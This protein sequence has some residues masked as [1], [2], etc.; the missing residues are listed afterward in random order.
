MDP[1][2]NPKRPD[3]TVQYPFFWEDIYPDT[4]AS[5]TLTVT[6]G[7]VTVAK[8]DFDPR[9][10][11]AFISGGASGETATIKCQ[12]VTNAGQ[13]LERTATLRVSTTGD[14][15]NPDS[16]LTKGA[17]VIHALGKLGIA[18]YVFDTEAEEDVSA[19][20]QLDSLASNWQSKLED[21]GYIQPTTRGASSPSDPSGI[22]A[23]DED[24]FIYNL[25][26]IIAD[27]YGKTPGRGVVR[28]AADT[29]ND[30]FIR[31]AKQYEYQ[32]SDKTP[33]GAGNRFWRRNRFPR[34][35]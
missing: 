26:E 12:I 35:V 33:V 30:L 4:I 14:S 23:A 29:R 11:Y 31:Y 34:A 13:T 6:S 15:L 10:V 28:R 8:S 1:S 27:G 25:A 24:A 19:L 9:T 21:F 2:W 22:N 7:T 16:T 20:R 3:E 32:L 5:F 17:L 18:N